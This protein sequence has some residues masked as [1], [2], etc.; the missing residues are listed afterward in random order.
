MVIISVRA[1][2]S[3]YSQGPG[4]NDYRVSAFSGT[5][6]VI[7]EHMYVI[8]PYQGGEWTQEG[9]KPLRS[10]QT[11]GQ[12]VFESLNIHGL[13]LNRDPEMILELSRDIADVTHHQPYSMGGIVLLSQDYGYRLAT[14]CDQGLRYVRSTFWVSQFFLLRHIAF[15]YFWEGHEIPTN[16]ALDPSSNTYSS[17]KARL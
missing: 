13:F 5:R 17:D 14:I 9:L 4:S 8:I 6:P 10:K 12:R 16:L 2:L 1:V 15:L 11:G 7:E 3:M